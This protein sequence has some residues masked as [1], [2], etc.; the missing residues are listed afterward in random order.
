EIVSCDLFVA[1]V[2][3]AYLGERFDQEEDFV[4]RELQL[5]CTAHRRIVPVILDSPE[6]PDRRPLP[7]W[8]ADFYKLQAITDSNDAQGIAQ[9]L[10]AE[11]RSIRLVDKSQLHEEL[12]SLKIVQ[13]ISRAGDVIPVLVSVG[14]DGELCWIKLSDG[15]DYRP[16]LSL[17]LKG[18]HVSALAVA[19]HGTDVRV[20]LGLTDSSVA[21][22]DLSNCELIDAPRL[23]MMWEY[24]TDL[25]PL[26]ANG[27]Y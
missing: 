26:V 24:N 16:R 9:R 14:R 15:Q 27:A 8:A 12:V 2:D 4:R 6:W 10:A 5:A 21:V 25:G 20:V 18:R 23:E 1:L 7:G 13:L 19:S 11:Y 22:C 3:K 17:D